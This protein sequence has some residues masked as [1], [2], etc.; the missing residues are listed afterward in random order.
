MNN[1]INDTVNYLFRAIFATCGQL[2]ILLGPGLFLAFVM[3]AIAVSVRRLA[4]QSLGRSIYL[5]LFGWLG[6]SVHE[7]GHA[8]FGLIFGHQIV[9]MQLFTPHSGTN[10]L[11]YVRVRYNPRNMYHQVGKLFVGIGPILFG[12]GVIYCAFL[13]LLA[14]DSLQSLGGSGVAVDSSSAMQNVGAILQNTIELALSILRSLFD[15]VNLLD[16]R[17][18]VFVYIAFAVGSS[19]T[20]SDSDIEGAS[21]GFFMVI[22]V[23][24]FFNLS[25]LWLGNFADDFSLYLSRLY[26]FF[27]AMM[28]FVIV[29]NLLLVTVLGLVVALARPSTRL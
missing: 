12:T 15:P 6:T 26:G 27:Y 5:G 2:F 24:F 16:W 18:Y 21:S 29:L 22:V 20:L 10:T 9:A 25:T 8:I 1:V 11:G 14:P 19:I 7:L 13:L 3:N 17:F 4:Y 23:T 28:L